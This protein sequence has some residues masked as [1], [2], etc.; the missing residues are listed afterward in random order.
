VIIGEEVEGYLNRLGD[1]LVLREAGR[2][3]RIEGR[4]DSGTKNRAMRSAR[5]SKLNANSRCEV[6]V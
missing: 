2:E 4:R 6:S 3:Q 5:P 1:A